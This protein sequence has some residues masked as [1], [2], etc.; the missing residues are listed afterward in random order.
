MKIALITIHNANNYGAILQAYATQQAFSKYGKTII[1]DYDNRHLA[2]SFNLIRCSLSIHGLKMLMHD[3]LRLP[4]RVRTLR[5]Y[6]KYIADN[7]M[8]S[9]RLT[10]ESL[11]DALLVQ[12]SLTA[13]RS[14]GA[15][16]WAA[17]R[18]GALLPLR[19]R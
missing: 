3:V 6:K 5:N 4:S 18:S 8:L 19:S 2:S 9:Q 17:P 15:L 11:K 1:L 13:A 10:S 14:G 7:L 12:P 16:R